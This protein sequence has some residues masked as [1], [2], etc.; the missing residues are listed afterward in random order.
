MT[1]TTGA[2]REHIERVLEIIKKT[3]RDGLMTD[4]RGEGLAGI[5]GLKTVGALQ[6]LVGLFADDSRACYL[7]IGV[8]QGLT[9]VSAALAAPGLACFGIDNFA[10]LDP[11]GKN[12][13]IATERLQ[14]FG[15]VNA[16]L[17]DSDFEAALADLDGRLDGR[18]IAVYFIDGPHDYRSQ[19]VCLLLALGHLHDRCVI[20][21]DDANYAC[22]RQA[23]A[24]FL[25][26]HPGFKMVFEAYGPAHP[27]N[28][29]G[30]EL[31]HWEEGWLNGVNVLVRDAEGLLP[32]MVPPTESDK[33]RHFNEWLIHR[34]RRAELAPEAVVLA[35]AI[36]TGDVAAEE[37]ARKALL[38]KY[39]IWRDISDGRYPDRN[40]ASGGLTEARF[41]E[42]SE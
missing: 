20:V 15:A 14:R 34:L 18:K 24:D 29:E 32:D 19:M 40:T 5:S 42:I 3:E 22:V 41:N 16:T 9:L 11:D 4:R 37:K 8:F 27:A 28:M 36:C 30:A 35:D 7:E 13:E 23:T 31:E 26:G 33:T 17:I 2:G 39:G 1:A 38:N 6:R 10:T 25:A 12:R 21:I